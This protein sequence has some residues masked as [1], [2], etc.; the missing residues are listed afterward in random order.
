MR[1]KR[2]LFLVA[3]GFAT[4]WF[5][6]PVSGDRRRRK[7]ASAIEPART[8]GRGRSTGGLFREGTM[9]DTMVGTAE[10]PLL[11]PPVV[12]MPMGDDPDVGVPVGGG[13]F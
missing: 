7:V 2:S 9:A 13:R 3:I 5:A 6:D 12:G 10:D 4:A 8:A 11:E 1:M